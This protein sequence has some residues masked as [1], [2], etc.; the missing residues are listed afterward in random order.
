MNAFAD[1]IKETAVF[2]FNKCKAFAKKHKAVSIISLVL[3]ILITSVFFTANYFL[4]KI[5]FVDPDNLTTVTQE[6]KKY[7]TLST[8]ETVD[9]TGLAKNSDGSY[10]LPDGRRFD[11]DGTVWNTDGSIVFYDGSY[12]LADGT[13]VLSDGTTIWKDSTVVFQSGNFIKKTGIEVDGQGYAKT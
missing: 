4:N 5:N 9:I 2:A 1:K 11:I 13:A 7:I 6:E 10:A 8:G 12:L 3:I